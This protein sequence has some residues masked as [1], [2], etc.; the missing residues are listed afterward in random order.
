[1]RLSIAYLCL[2]ATYGYLGKHTVNAS[3]TIYSTFHDIFKNK[4][5]EDKRNRFV[6][7]GKSIEEGSL[8]QTSHGKR[9]KLETSDQTESPTAEAGISHSFPSDE[10]ISI[11]WKN[12][13]RD[14]TSYRSP[15][16]PDSGCE[17][18][19]G[20]CT[21]LGHILTEEQIFVLIQSCPKSC[22]IPCE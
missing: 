20:D 4:D 10:L 3:P 11:S 2:T 21:Q 7:T 12:G 15:L 6:G 18:H 17:I 22:K 16:K 14:Q 13:C 1:M 9:L 8:L 5:R 19:D